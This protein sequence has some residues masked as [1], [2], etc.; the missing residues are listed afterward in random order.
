[1]PCAML[2]MSSTPCAPGRRCP[3]RNRR[4]ACNRRASCEQAL[5][6][7]RVLRVLD[8]DR[9]SRALR[10]HLDV[11]AALPLEDEVRGLAVLAG[12]VEV[13]RALH[14]G[15]RDTAVQVADDL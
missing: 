14:A 7:P 10:Q 1:M 13:D 3:A 12:R 2:M 15:E 5:A 8:G 6:S 9:A 4:A 11:L